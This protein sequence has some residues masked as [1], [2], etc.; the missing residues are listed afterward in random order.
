MAYYFF[1]LFFLSKRVW[2]TI[3]KSKQLLKLLLFISS[4]YMRTLVAKTLASKRKEKKIKTIF[5]YCKLFLSQPHHHV[6]LDRLFMHLLIDY[7]IFKIFV[8][9]TK[10]NEVYHI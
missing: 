3:L 10:V 4:S 1:C 8:K 9:Y 2:L 5:I 7:F 6:P